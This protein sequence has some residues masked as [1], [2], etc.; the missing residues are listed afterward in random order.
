MDLSFDSRQRLIGVLLPLAVLATN[1]QA[2]AQ[3]QTEIEPC[4]PL[5]VVGAPSQTE[6]SKKVSIPSFLVNNTNWN[7]DFA[8]PSQA[9]Y[10]RFVVT[11]TPT[12]GTT[13]DLAVNLKYNDDTVDGV[14]QE[15]N[16][17]LPLNEP[18]MI[19][20]PTRT[21]QTPYQVNILVG[22]ANAVDHEYQASVM[23]CID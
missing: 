22:G 18:F 3:T 15:N 9:S 17:T 19:E 4:I 14:Y 10:R 12:V 16:A 20:V 21:D 2:Q 23:G 1:P 13:Y 5:T 8:V 11:I 6:V 7:T